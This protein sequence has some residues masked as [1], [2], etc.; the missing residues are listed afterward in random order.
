MKEV[1]KDLNR[2]AGENKFNSLEKIRQILLTNEPFT[3][4][5]DI[6]TPTMKIKRNVAKILFA[7]EIED[8]YA[9]PVINV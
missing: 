7:K 3:Q 2:L 6:L 1:V 9:K 4:E 5:N 8:M